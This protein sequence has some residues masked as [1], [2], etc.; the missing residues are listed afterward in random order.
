MFSFSSKFAIGTIR[1][2]SHCRRGRAI[3]T[4]AADS[5]ACTLRP[6]RRSTTFRRKFPEHGH[7]DSPVGKRGNLDLL[8]R[9]SLRRCRLAHVI[10]APRAP[11]R[12]A[13]TVIPAR[14]YI[15]LHLALIDLGQCLKYL[16]LTPGRI[17]RYSS[18]SKMWG[19]LTKMNHL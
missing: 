12:I 3:A 10:G 8:D 6:A 18:F 1:A 7:S 11:F 14:Y 2:R 9:D 19:E 4:G 13:V 17:W 5:R 15:H 16:V